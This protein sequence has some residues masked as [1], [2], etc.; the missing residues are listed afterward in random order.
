LFGWAC[1]GAFVVGERFLVWE[2]YL[3]ASLSAFGLVGEWIFGVLVWEDCPLLIAALSL[4][5]NV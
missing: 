3:L 4:L 1:G 5:G 2:M